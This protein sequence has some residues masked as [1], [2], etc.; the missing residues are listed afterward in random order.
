MVM[1][2][3]ELK[4]RLLIVKLGH[5]LSGWLPVQTVGELSQMGFRSHLG[6]VDGIGDVAVVLMR[7]QSSSSLET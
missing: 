2:L 7:G 5:G 1:R 4:Q 3:E 6:A